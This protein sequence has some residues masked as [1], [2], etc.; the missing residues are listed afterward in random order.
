MA[1][2]GRNSFSGRKLALIVG[3]G[4]YAHAYNILKQS[5]NNA[6]DLSLTL[7]AIGFQVTTLYNLSKNEMTTCII[8]FANSITHDDIVLIYFSGHCYEVNGSKYLL[9]VDDINI[10]SEHD[11]EGF[12]V[13]F[14][15]IIMKLVERGPPF[16]TIYI[17]DCYQPYSINGSPSRKSTGLQ[18]MNSPI[19]T[20]ITFACDENQRG[21][22]N[23][24]TDRNS[25][26]TNSLLKYVNKK[27]VDI[28]ELL[29]Q[30]ADEVRRTSREKQQPI[31]MNGLRE[32]RNVYLNEETV[33]INGNLNIIH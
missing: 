14:E 16:V 10:K 28:G 21:S 8:E 5:V 9:P 12:A 2:A 30:I 25:L 1:T 6:K 31:L 32:Y 33:T 29:L 27:N 3:N 26:Y 24:E 19:N 22:D 15:L 4:T 17:L 23:R 7:N 20:F 11:M 13:D 18:K